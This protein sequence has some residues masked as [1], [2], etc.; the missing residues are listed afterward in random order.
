MGTEKEVDR[1]LEEIGLVLETIHGKS[2]KLGTKEE[3]RREKEA[4]DVVA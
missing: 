3:E 4:N 1:F 2:G